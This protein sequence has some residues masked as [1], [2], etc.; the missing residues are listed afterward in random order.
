VIIV[1]ALAVVASLA[2]V[3]APVVVASLAVAGALAVVASL[4]RT[5][6]VVGT[7]MI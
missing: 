6:D 1:V 2:V 3:G 7:G 4:A 5:V